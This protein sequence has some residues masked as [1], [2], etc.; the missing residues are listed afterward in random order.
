MSTVV[1][2][3]EGRASSHLAFDYDG[4]TLTI[5]QHI[6]VETAR[7]GSASGYT[8]VLENT[9]IAHFQCTEEDAKDAARMFLEEL[10]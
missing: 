8:R 3:D 5:T 2:V 6:V 10:L 9:V 7:E 1:K 4:E